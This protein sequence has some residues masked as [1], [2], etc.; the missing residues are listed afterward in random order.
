MM[1]VVGAAFA[2]VSE[3]Q[4]V[5]SPDTLLV[6]KNGAEVRGS[7]VDFKEGLYTLRLPDGRVMT[8]PAGDVE[9]MERLATPEPT[10]VAS[11]PQPTPAPSPFTC[12]TFISEK[13]VDK[14]F[15][16]TIKDIKVSKKWYGSTSV[17]YGHLAEKARKTGADAVINVHTWHAPSGFAWAAPHAG[18][19]AIKWT[20]AGRKAL[21]SLEGLC[22]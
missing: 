12:R 22:Y 11:A 20:E 16:T 4:D 5:A 15:Y 1:C 21:P 2:V 7:F 9:R 17:M 8:Y 13:D 3:G 10:P 19:M 18:G 6:L 14:S